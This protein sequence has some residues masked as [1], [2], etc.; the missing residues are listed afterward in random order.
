MPRSKAK[1]CARSTYITYRKEHKYPA[2]AIRATLTKE[3][4]RTLDSVNWRGERWG[5]CYGLWMFMLAR[6]VCIIV[7]LM[8]G[9]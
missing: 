9:L 1:L 5:W 7:F 6:A 3:C 4:K 2:F 8:V